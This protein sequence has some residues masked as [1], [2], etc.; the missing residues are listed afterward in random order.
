MTPVLITDVL[1]HAGIEGLGGVGVSCFFLLCNHD[2]FHGRLAPLN[3]VVHSRA[4]RL[5]L[6]TALSVLTSA[7]TVALIDR[8]KLSAGLGIFTL[9][10]A[11]HM[12]F[13]GAGAGLRLGLHRAFERVSASQPARLGLLA[14]AYLALATLCVSTIG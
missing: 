13:E 5:A 11:V 8:N 4:W 12:C 2:H 14:A 6:L 10:V 9:G 7:A 1:G 3:A